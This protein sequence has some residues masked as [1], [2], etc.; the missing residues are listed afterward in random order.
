MSSSSSTTPTPPSSVSPSAKQKRKHDQVDKEPPP[1][2]PQGSVLYVEL[3]ALSP[4]QRHGG[5]LDYRW[6][7]LLAPD[8]KANTR[9]RRYSVHETTRPKA[10]A[11]G[12]ARRSYFVRE[13]DGPIDT[14][15]AGGR[16][17]T[18]VGRLGREFEGMGLEQQQLGRSSRLHHNSPAEGVEDGK[19]LKE[20]KLEIQDVRIQASQEAQV[21]VRLSR[22]QDVESFEALVKD[23]LLES[24]GNRGS[25]WNPVVW[26]RDVWIALTEAEDVLGVKSPL[27]L[28]KLM[29]WETVRETAVDFFRKEESTGRLDEKILTLRVPTWGL[30]EKRVMVA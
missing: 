8:D 7:F 27:K 19:E 16:S 14:A 5:V 17:S 25:E 10:H 2:P 13:T 15:Q 21:R 1:P 6:A 30:L 18:R 3:Y 29:D 20:W 22:I 26:M 24:D 28:A 4:S 12:R 9:G 11:H 23:A